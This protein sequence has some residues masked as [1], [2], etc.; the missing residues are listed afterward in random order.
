MA[1]TPEERKLRA[2][3]AAHTMHA[4]VADPSAHT[5]PARDAFLAKFEHEVDPEGVLKPEERKRRAEHARKAH[6]KRLS[7]L[8]AQA[9][10]R[11]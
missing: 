9:R 4:Q 6:F 3:L 11:R 2:Q 10:R 8:A 5:R 1:L 7:L